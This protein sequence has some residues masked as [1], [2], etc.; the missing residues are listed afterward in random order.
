MANW[1]QISNKRYGNIKIAT[2][3]GRQTN[4]IPKHSNDETI[5]S[6]RAKN[7]DQ[8]R[9][10]EQKEIPNTHPSMKDCLGDGEKFW[11]SSKKKSPKDLF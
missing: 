2:N 10:N 7:N 8:H 4:K 6:I 9:I 11:I 1:K 3:H 5:V